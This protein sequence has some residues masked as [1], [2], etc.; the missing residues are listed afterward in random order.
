MKE[1]TQEDLKDCPPWVQSGAVDQEGDAWGYECTTKDLSYFNRG[2]HAMI[3]VKHPP[4]HI[5]S[6]YDAEWWEESAIN[7]SADEAYAKKV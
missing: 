3:H 4:Y 1:F 7:G 2:H 5:G 6:G